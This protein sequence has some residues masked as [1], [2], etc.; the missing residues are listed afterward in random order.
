MNKLYKYKKKL[1]H[2]PHGRG[3]E[4]TLIVDGE[5]SFVEQ[6]ITRQ[7]FNQLFGGCLTTEDADSLFITVQYIGVWGRD[8]VRQF[9]KLLRERG[10]QFEICD[11]DETRRF[12]KTTTQSYG[13]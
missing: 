10:A 2:T 8:K 1:P 12:I 7:E 5:R 4:K 11:I 9:T 3:N 13:C 6:Y